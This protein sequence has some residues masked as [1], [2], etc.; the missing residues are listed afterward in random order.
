M[1]NIIKA[2]LDRLSEIMEVYQIARE[3]MKKTNNPNQWGDTHPPLEL[4]KDHIFNGN[5]YIGINEN[6]EIL[7]S[8]AFI[9]GEDPTYKYIENGKWID[10]SL[11]GTIHSLASAQKIN[12]V[13]SYVLAF[14][15]TKTD[16]IRID[17]HE[18][19]KVFQHILAKFN[20]K[21]CGV[22]F[23]KNGSPRFAYELVV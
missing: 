5:L 10:N 17:T 22:I 14:C 11:Y 18:D 19:N 20:F 3:Y 6:N 15:L 12:N 1:V 23:L 13:F 21:K 9:I 7:F 8:F 2:S 16:H 4:I